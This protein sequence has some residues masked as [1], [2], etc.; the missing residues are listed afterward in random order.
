MIGDVLGQDWSNVHT[1][2][3]VLIPLASRESIPFTT[4]CE[5]PSRITQ[6]CTETVISG[7]LHKL[8]GGT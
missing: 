7:T 6:R 8:V 2:S 5:M 3:I 4:F 1:F